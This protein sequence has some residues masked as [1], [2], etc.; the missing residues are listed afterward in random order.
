MLTSGAGDTQGS[1]DAAREA[2]IGAYLVKPIR[3]A[4]LLE[5]ILDLLAGP[6]P[7]EPGRENASAREPVPTGP[8]ASILLVDDVVD[9]RMLVEAYLA[10]TTHRVTSVSD[11]REAVETYSEDPGGFD[12]VFMDIRMPGM[13]GYEATGLMRSL[14]A[15]RG[16]SPVPIVALTAHA[17]EEER[18]KTA[19]AGFDGHITKP[20]KK[21][22]LLDAIGHFARTGP[23]ESPDRATAGPEATSADGAAEAPEFPPSGPIVIPIEPKLARL[24]PGFLDN[25][26]ADVSRVRQAL[27][28]EDLEMIERI[29]H[30][31]KGVGGGFGFD[32]VTT[33][34]AAIERLSRE[35]SV[36]EIGRWIDSLADYLERVDPQ[37]REEAG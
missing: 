34:G 33:V 37:V 10:S 8:G 18:E 36:G 25:R 9:N 6:A 35:R 4:E 31:M 7:P 21:G 11:G 29:G 28:E 27:D 24:V 15:E 3:R 1:P 17:L 13:D 19:A 2:G 14:E 30:G 22:L 16:I 5:A 12:L 23:G 32:Y 20:I 26:R